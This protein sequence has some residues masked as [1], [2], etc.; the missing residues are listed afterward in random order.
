LIGKRDEILKLITLK[1]GQVFSRKNIMEIQANINRFLGD[2]GYGVP[3]IG[4][5]PV[6]DDNNKQI[7]LKFMVNP[8]QRVYIRRINFSGNTKTHDEVL[9]R[10]MRL[11]EG[12]M[13]SLSKIEES[14]RLLA[15][16]GYLEDVEYKVTP[17][18]DEPRQMDLTYSVKD[19]SS[20]SAAIQGGVSDAEGFL[21]GANVNDT[22]FLGT[23]KTASI[24]FDNSRATQVYSL[25]Y[26]DPYFTNNHIGFSV[27]GYLNKTNTGK[28]QG[29]SSYSTDIYG[30]LASFVIPLSDRDNVTLGAGI[31]HIK[32]KENSGTP[33][34]IWDF[35]QKY[36]YIYDEIKLVA[37]WQHS[38]MNRAIFPTKGFAQ[39]LSLAGYAPIN[40]RSLEF[41]TIEHTTSWFQ[42]LFSDFIFHTRTDLGYGN[43]L[44]KTGELP[45][46]KHFFAGGIGSV[47]GFEDGD[48]GIG[49]T[50][51]QDDNHRAIGGNIM[52]V[53][54]ASIIIPS[55]VMKDTIR[56]SIFVDVGNVYNNKFRAHDLRGSCGVQ[57]EWR[58]PLMPLVFSLA[59]AVRKKDGDRLSVFQFSLSTSI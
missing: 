21:Y 8:G 44:G 46:F 15:N 47:R 55:P 18:Q 3:E 7:F 35:I 25:G 48:L 13:F 38:S 56:P 30:A 1:S 33:Q 12:S 45:F 32:L 49:D 17:V 58:S 28:L 39:S 31:E 57:I 22:N 27:N 40:K 6:V 4:V 9:R 2:Y 16:L 11:Q 19:A 59:K 5:D 41:Y 54:S 29:R 36:G 43:G 20:T 42:P 24:R 26:Y 50:D 23:G 52:T 14:K 34:Y 37:N 10:E 51:A 53:G